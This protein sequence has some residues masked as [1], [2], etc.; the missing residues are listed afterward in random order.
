[1]RLRIEA[2]LDYQFARPTDVLLALEVAHADDQP[3]VEDC[4]TV[5]G[6]G[7]LR[8][9]PGECGIGQ[10]TWATA[11]GRFVA[12]YTATVDVDRALPDLSRLTPVPAREASA[13]IVQFLWP[14]RYC[15]SDRLCAFVGREF[16]G[17]R[18]GPA[19][20]AMAAWIE[21]RLDYVRGSSDAT[22]TALD[23][24][25]KRQ[26]ICR[27]YA[28][29]MVTF[30]RAADIPARMVAVYGLGVQPPDFHAVAEVWLADGGTPGWHLVD[31]TGMT[32]AD[33]LA[34]IA[35]G[36]DAT[37]VSF[38]TSFGTARLNSQR[39]RVERVP[40]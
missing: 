25:I 24:F 10:R 11:N 4:L 19:V 34:R 1:M 23:S 7:P 21:D 5:D 29:L 14:S 27:D 26:G 20:V 9:I 2:E 17:L 13:D 40:G 30:A 16:A 22:T 38:M 31:A 3:L 32:R 39:V 18:G 12:R 36:R 15:Q 33:G 6:S 8:P 28:H 37:D 35:V